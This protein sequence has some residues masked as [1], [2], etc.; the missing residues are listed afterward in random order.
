MREKRSIPFEITSIDSLGQGVSKLTD[1]V[2]FIPKTT[3]GDKG[4][5]N[6]NS[7]KKGVVFA[8]MERL[9]SCSSERIIPEC[10]H[11]EK[12]PSC[13]FLHVP[14]DKEL[15][16]KKQNFEKL[17]RKL[18]LSQVEIVGA[19]SRF[20]YR[21]RIQLHYSLK[22]KLI[23]MRQPHSFEIL[24]IPKC[25]IGLTEIQKELHRLYENE[26]WL[27][28]APA[29]PMEG[30]LEIYWMNNQIQLNWNKPYA[31]GGFTQV[32]ALMNEKLKSVIQQYWSTHSPMT[33]LDLFGGNGNL[34]DAL[35][36]SS[37]LCVDI[38]PSRKEE[39]FFHQNLYDE[40]ALKQVQIKL[41]SLDI[42]VNHLLLDPPRSGFKELKLWL[43]CFRPEHVAYISCDPHTMARDLAGIDNYQFTKAILLDF[44]PSTFHFETLIFLERKT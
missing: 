30:H 4:T 37:R 14:Y 41:T 44:F 24:P 42:D 11:F 38:Y 39:G 10:P 9:N 27:K 31:D 6:I 25:K 7:E 33:L 23:G 16:Y 26:N 20:G 21:N 12:C 19:P 1:K 22:N 18:T 5:A 36:Y 34:S 13:H 8:S 17:F 15:E 29:A 32:Y 40:K 3:V 2:T 35:N 28:E 43:E